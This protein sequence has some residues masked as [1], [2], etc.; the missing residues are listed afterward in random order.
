MNTQEKDEV[1][2]KLSKFYDEWSFVKGLDQED[3]DYIR[4]LIAR[5]LRFGYENE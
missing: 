4:L 3:T 1:F 5:L 2:E